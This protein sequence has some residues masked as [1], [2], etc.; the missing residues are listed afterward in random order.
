MN[1]VGVVECG[2][3]WLTR[4]L[5]Y[6]VCSNLEINCMVQWEQRGGGIT[7]RSVAGERFSSMFPGCELWFLSNS[8]TH[9]HKTTSTLP[10]YTPEYCFHGCCCILYLPYVAFI[11]AK[12]IVFFSWLFERCVVFVNCWKYCPAAFINFTLCFFPCCGT[13]VSLSAL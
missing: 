3:F 6:G 10:Q 7:S 11:F 2:T 4:E 8:S 5:P 1:M 12:H 13:F 9:T